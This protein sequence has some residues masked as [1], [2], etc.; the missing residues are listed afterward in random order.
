MPIILKDIALGDTVTLKKPH[1]CGG[2]AFVVTRTGAD[3]KLQCKT[4]GHTVM[5]PGESVKKAV[6]SIEKPQN[7]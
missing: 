5:L 2:N 7:E 4:C 1:P 6:K 3:Y